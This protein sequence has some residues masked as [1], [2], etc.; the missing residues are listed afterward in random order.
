MLEVII[1]GGAFSRVAFRRGVFASDWFSTIN[2]ASH[3]SSKGTIVFL[4]RTIKRYQIPFLLSI[5]MEAGVTKRDTGR[6]RKS[7][8]R[9]DKQ[10]GPD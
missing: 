3:L 7:H 9:P 5:N 1:R 4:A 8:T 10:V 2:P 6:A